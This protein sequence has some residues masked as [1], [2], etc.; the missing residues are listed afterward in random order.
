MNNSLSN[1]SFGAVRNR[2]NIFFQSKSKN[3]HRQNRFKT[4]NK[5]LIQADSTGFTTGFPERI[6]SSGSETQLNKKTSDKYQQFDDQTD[7]MRHILPPA[8]VDK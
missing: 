3:S 5:G 6:E 2:T 8:W 1:Y 4:K 7:Y